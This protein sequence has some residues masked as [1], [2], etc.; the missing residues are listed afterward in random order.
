MGST[1]EQRRLF[2][3]AGLPGQRAR[4][5][6]EALDAAPELQTRLVTLIV[7]ARNTSQDGDLAAD[8]VFPQTPQ[9][10]KV[11]GLE[12]ELGSACIFAPDATL[13]WRG[14]VAGFELDETDVISFTYGV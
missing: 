12:V 14:S 9:C 5:L 1:E 2:H 7:A 6:V 3:R 8:T 4:R 10:V 13:L 11:N